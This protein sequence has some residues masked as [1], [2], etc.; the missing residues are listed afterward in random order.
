MS[1]GSRI[2]LLIV[3]DHPVVRRGLADIFQRTGR[4]PHA[5]INFITAHDGF[6]LHDLVSYNAK[7]NEANGENNKDGI[8][9]NLSWNHG[10]EGPSD[11][12]SIVAKR[13]QSK[14]NMIATLLLARGAPMLQ[15]GDELGRTQKG[16]NNA[17]CQDNEA[18]WVDW[19]LDAHKR[20]LVEFTARMV[21][22]RRVE[23]VLREDWFFQG[24]HVADSRF[25]DLT[26][27]RADGKEMSRND[28]KDGEMHSFGYL[29]AGDT[30]VVPRRAGYPPIG[31][32]L[33]VLLNA[34]HGAVTFRVPH[35][36]FPCSWEMIVETAAP[37]RKCQLAG[38]AKLELVGRSLAVLRLRLVGGPQREP[39]E[40]PAG[41]PPEPRPGGGQ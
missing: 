16:N 10:V 23:G 19:S 17:Y 38:D 31:D 30:L 21:K 7:H 9:N 41:A 15:A 8:D 33:L 20:A 40:P 4:R 26:F 11:D 18:S 6:T 27:Y 22:L 32:T 5:S 25:K 13:E 28:W 37:E 2:R 35:M 12:A 1:N 39:A 14:R 3:D 34:F 29:L 36:H 24:H